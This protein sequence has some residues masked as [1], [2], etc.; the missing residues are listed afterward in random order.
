M[1]KY[2]KDKTEGKY[3]ETVCDTTNDAYFEYL[4][5]EQS[6]LD[7]KWYLPE[8]C[9]HFTPE[10][11]EKKEQE[12]IGNLQVTKRV[13]ALGLQKLG[14]TYSQLKA[15]IATNE[16]AQLE[17]DLCVELQ[18]KNPLLDVMG[19]QL[20]VTPKMI[21]NIFLKANGEIIENELQ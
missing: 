15:L 13:F 1:Y 20:G 5:V 10:E 19:A 6:E 16:Q 8:E 12:R 7:G 3:F 21:D 18:R 14:I 17:W 9:P 2:V 11:Q 4:D